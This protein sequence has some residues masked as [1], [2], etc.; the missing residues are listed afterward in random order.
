MVVC[1]AV[2]GLWVFL[3]TFDTFADVM[4]GDLPGHLPALL[5]VQQFFSEN[6]M[7]PPMP[8]PSLSSITPSDFFSLHEISPQRDFLLIG[9]G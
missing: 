9:K 2:H 4:M 6:S 5:G 8:C 7:T 3:K 1:E